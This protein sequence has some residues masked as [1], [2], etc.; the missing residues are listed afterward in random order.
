MPRSVSATRNV[1]LEGSRVN[2]RDGFAT[3]VDVS[4]S[5]NVLGLSV[6]VKITCVK[7]ML[8]ENADETTFPGARSPKLN[9]STVLSL[10]VALRTMLS[11]V[12][13]SA[14]GKKPRLLLPVKLFTAKTFKPE[15]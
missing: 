6:A 13:L 7:S 10:S 4:V 14:T 2:D 1:P 15:E 3:N 5:V 12:T 11:K 9:V 8:D